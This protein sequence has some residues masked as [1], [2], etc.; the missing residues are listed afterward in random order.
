MI[1][2]YNCIYNYL[3]SV[4][5]FCFT[6]SALVALIQEWTLTM[7]GYFY[8]LSKATDMVLYMFTCI[9]CRQTCIFKVAK[10]ALQ[11]VLRRCIPWV[12]KTPRCAGAENIMGF[13]TLVGCEVFN[14]AA[15][16]V[17]AQRMEADTDQDKERRLNREEAAHRK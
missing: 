7:D 12:A 16:R 4:C 13:R 2:V 9:M 11:D 5:H 14:H 6:N 15:G 10:K 3:E 17:R 8:G 1:V